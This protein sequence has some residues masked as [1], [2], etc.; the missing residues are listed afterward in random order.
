M[1]DRKKTVTILGSTGSIG[2][3]ALDVISRLPDEFEIAYLT[4]NRNT[5][6]LAEQIARYSPKGVVVGTSEAA[7]ELRSQI[8]FSGEILSGREQLCRVAS[9]SQN[10]LII[11]SLVGFSGVLPTLAAI[12]AGK[13]VALA[14]KETLVSAGSIITRRAREMNV[15]LLAID[16]E[17]SGILQCLAGEQSASIEKLILT[18][19][20]GPFLNTPIEEFDRITVSQALAHPNWS[21]GNKITIDSA[22][23]MNKGFEV[24]EAYW[25]F[26]VDAA[27]IDVVIHPRS[28]VH[29][30][31]QFTDGSIKAQLGLPDM[32]I[33]ISY[34]LTYPERR[35]F[36]FPRL[37]LS[38][39]RGLDF[40]PPDYEK[41]PCLRMA[42]EALEAGGTVP[43]VINAANEVAVAA[44]LESRIPFAGIP[45]IIE[46]AA[47]RIAS[48]SEPTIED[49][50]GTD[51]EARAIAES[52]IKFVF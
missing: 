30:L 49:I 6:L 48:I 37:D 38:T 42:F 11:S 40:F 33:P 50:V 26:G 21:M 22:T 35:A 10:D 39:L 19:S 23:M 3:Q 47:E 32:R 51:E 43:A 20:G 28:I 9:D 17:H 52:F 12:D 46:N 5:G 4:A 34:A 31:V 45:K 24:I 44:F 27:Q 36:D 7:S 14:N 13:T 2:T 16:S 1:A 25:L 29:S 41:F 18:A 15:P 8:N